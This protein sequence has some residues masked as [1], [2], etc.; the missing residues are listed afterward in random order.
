MWQYTISGVPAIK[1]RVLGKSSKIWDEYS[2]ARMH[3]ENELVF[4]RGDLPKHEGLLDVSYLFYLPHTFA[5]TRRA[6]K[7]KSLYADCKPD[8]L[9]LINFAQ[10]MVD[11]FL[12]DHGSVIVS[13]THKKLYHKHPGTVIYV[14]PMTNKK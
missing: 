14:K 12:L 13:G 3:A 10:A 11:E 6:L 5:S 8:L 7:I 2:A 1:F 4:Q 9:L